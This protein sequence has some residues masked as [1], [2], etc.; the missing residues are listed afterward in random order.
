MTIRTVSD[1]GDNFLTIETTKE[2]TPLGPGNAVQLIPVLA[3]WPSSP[4]QTTG[5]VGRV[6]RIGA[7]R[8]DWLPISAGIVDYGEMIFLIFQNDFSAIF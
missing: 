5:M 6:G 2:V 4:A 8:A 3:S 7:T 1:S